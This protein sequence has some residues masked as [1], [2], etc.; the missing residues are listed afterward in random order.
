MLNHR[1]NRF[2]RGI[3]AA[4]TVVASL[5]LTLVLLAGVSVMGSTLQ[6]WAK[7]TTRVDAENEAAY[8]VRYIA[9]QIQEAYIATVSTDGNTLT[10]YLP[11]KDDTGDY[12]TPL[13][14][15][16]SSRSF[17]VSNGALYE[18]SGEETRVLLSHIASTDP[19]IPGSD[20]SYRVFDAGQGVITHSVTIHL[21]TERQTR[22]AEN[23]TRSRH[24]QL[25]YIR[26]APETLQ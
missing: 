8:A 15:E 13:A 1:Y 7:N 2:R 20:K 11:D 17:Y 16:A 18:Q 26:N 21:V 22:I 6:S 10:Y 25:V 23:M 12:K 9:S 5:I 24:R 3:T 14:K 4:E 19:T